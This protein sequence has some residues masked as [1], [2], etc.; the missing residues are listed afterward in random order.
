MKKIKILAFFTTLTSL[1]AAIT[2]AVACTKNYQIFQEDFDMDLDEIAESSLDIN[3]INLKNS[4]NLI[5]SSATSMRFDFSK[6]HLKNQSLLNKITEGWK[7][8]RSQKL[9]SQASNEIFGTSDFINN[10]YGVN[11][12]SLQLFAR[13]LNDINKDSTKLSLEEMLLDKKSWYDKSSLNFRNWD[14]AMTFAVDKENELV[15]NF[16]NDILTYLLGLDKQDINLDEVSTLPW[17][18]YHDSSEMGIG[19]PLNEEATLFYQ[20][21]KHSNPELIKLINATSTKDELLPEDFLS[22]NW[23]YIPPIDNTNEAGRWVKSKTKLLNDNEKVFEDYSNEAVTRIDITSTKAAIV[24]TSLGKIDAAVVEKKVIVKDEN[25]NDYLTPGMQISYMNRVSSSSGSETGSLVNQVS[26]NVMHFHDLPLTPGIANQTTLFIPRTVS[27]SASA[28][29]TGFNMNP[30]RSVKQ[31]YKFTRLPEQPPITK[32]MSGAIKPDSFYSTARLNRRHQIASAYVTTDQST[33][34]RQLSRIPLPSSN[35]NNTN[36]KSSQ[37]LISFTTGIDDPQVAPSLWNME[38]YDRRTHAF[39]LTKADS[40]TQTPASWMKKYRPTTN[41][42]INQTTDTVT[43]VGTYTTTTGA[44]NRPIGST[45][46]PVERVGFELNNSNA[47]NVGGGAGLHANTR[48]P[49]P[50]LDN[51][52]AS[53]NLTSIRAKISRFTSTKAFR[54]G[55]AVTGAAITAALTAVIIVLA[56]RDKSRSELLADPGVSRAFKPAPYSR[57]LGWEAREFMRKYWQYKDESQK[58][59]DKLHLQGNE[60]LNSSYRYLITVKAEV[61][62]SNRKLTK[63]FT[64]ADQKWDLTNS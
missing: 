53:T 15:Q 52:L 32:P 33:R 64:L 50:S 13:E 12:K 28:A 48:L 63:T 5:Q 4:L 30:P 40:R 27:P 29:S 42:Q 62:S 57:Q 20:Y 36:R 10:P 43:T 56:L 8:V 2:T 1:G 7:N 60:F 9:I 22:E 25:D 6:N 55:L 16:K 44:S 51:R 49:N 3:Q 59:V 26:G 58:Q 35:V 61:P 11:D 18:W 47:M 54:I 37:T 17:S 34:Q 24:H 38:N 21:L 39:V 19:L 41:T 45:V 23:N 46:G 14:S 31:V